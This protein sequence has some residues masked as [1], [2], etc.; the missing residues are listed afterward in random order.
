M[1]KDDKTKRTAGLGLMFALAIVLQFVEN[2][3]PSPF[4]FAP[5]IRLG[6]SNI[7][8]MFCLFTFGLP[9]ALLIALLKGLFAL[10]TRGPAAGILSAAGG[11]ASVIVMRLMKETGSSRGLISVLGAVTHNLA[12]LL[13]ECLMMKSSAAMYYLPVLVI[14]GIIM[15]SLTALVL[16]AVTPY[17]DRL[18]SFSGRITGD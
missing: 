13:A 3:I 8:T 10:V 5:G 12:Q 15:G 16:K 17:L 11:I 7:V 14:S 1:R 6:L 18:S 9:D 4:S 2:L